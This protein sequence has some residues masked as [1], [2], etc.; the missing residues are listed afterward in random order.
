MSRI[1][2]DPDFSACTAPTA[3]AADSYYRIIGRC[4][5]VWRLHRSRIG[6]VVADGSGKILEIQLNT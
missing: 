5:S 6:S 4:G 1:V 3:I 2:A